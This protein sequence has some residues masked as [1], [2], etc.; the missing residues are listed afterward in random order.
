[1]VLK[2]PPELSVV[3]NWTG[4]VSGVWLLSVVLNE[5]PRALS[6]VL[7]PRSVHGVERPS[8]APSPRTPNLASPGSP[9]DSP[10][11]SEPTDPESTMAFPAGQQRD[12][13]RLCHSLQRPSEH[14]HQGGTNRVTDHP[15]PLSRP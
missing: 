10:A 6:I 9:G 7:S 1:M 5:P 12:P 15:A 13:V 8:L 4:A 3:L 2:K 14:P 11:A